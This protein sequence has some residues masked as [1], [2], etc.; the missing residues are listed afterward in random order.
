MKNPESGIR[1]PKFQSAVAAQVLPAHS[2]TCRL[3]V[4]GCMALVLL[5]GGGRTAADTVFHDDFNGSLNPAWSVV[6]PDASYYSVQSTGL[7]LR[8]SN[9]DLW[10]YYNNAKNVFL[11]A[12]PAGGDFTL[13]AK[14]RWSV[15]PTRPEAQ[16]DLLAYDNDDNHVRLAHGLL[17][18][19]LRI[20]S[21]GETGGVYAGHGLTSVNFGTAWFWLQM[22]KQGSTYSAWYSSDGITFNQASSPFTYGDGTP[23]QLGLVAMADPYGTA[24]VIVDSFTVEDTPVPAS[25]FAL[26]WWTIDG[27]GG[28]LTNTQFTLSG[29]IGQPDASAMSGGNFTLQGGFWSILAAVQTEGAP[30]LSVLRTTTNTVIVSWPLPTAGWVLEWTNALSQVSASWPQIPPPYQTNGANLQFT[31]PAPAGAKFYRLHKP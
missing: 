11:I 1:S 19:V 8:C 3:P 6:R 24:Q 12:N 29:T 14:L 18:G 27:G 16:V 25:N 15:V 10:T 7:V 9:S 17:S 5:A 4:I 30:L 13:T 28:T 23:A 22:R 26:D 2:E 20:D 31:E 21:A